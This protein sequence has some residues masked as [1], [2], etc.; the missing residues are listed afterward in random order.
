MNQFFLKPVICGIFFVLLISPLTEMAQ[1]KKI[2]SLRTLLKKTTVIGG[3]IGFKDTLRIKALQALTYAYRESRDFSTAIKYAQIAQ[4]ISEKL[5][6]NTKSF[7][8]KIFL[9]TSLKTVGDIYRSMEDYSNALNL[10]KKELKVREEIGNK[11]D[12]ALCYNSIGLI[13]NFQDDLARSLEYFFKA[14]KT[15]E[16]A[17]DK[18]ELTRIYN[19]LGIAYF[20]QQNITKALEY[21]TKE[22]VEGERLKDER[23]VATA[24]MNMGAIYAG[25]GN[26]DSAL[27]EFIKFQKISEKRNDKAGIALA[28]MDIGEIYARKGNYAKALEFNTKAMKLYEEA[29]YKSD[30]ALAYYN[31]GYIYLSMAIKG[32]QKKKTNLAAAN[33]YLKKALTLHEQVGQI[34]GMQYCYE[35]LSTLDS[36]TGNAKGELEN[37]KKYVRYGDSLRNQEN[38]VQSIRTEMNY[39][40]EKKQTSANLQ[41]TKKET[42]ATQENDKQKALRNLFIIAFVFMLILSIFIFK[43]YRQKKLVNNVISLQKIEVEKQK[44]IVEKNQKQ[45]IDSINYAK[46]IQSSMLPNYTILKKAFK[47]NFIFYKPKDIVSGDFY[48]FY[49]L[50]GKNETIVVIADCT[51]HG[52]PGAFLS[53]IGTTLLNEIV[54]HKNITDPAEIIK[55][56][57]AGLISTLVTKKKE[58]HS[59]G[60]DISICKIN[61]E[62]KTLYFAG[63]NQILCLVNDHQVEKIESQVNSIDGVFDLSYSGNFVSTE[64]KLKPSTALFMSTDGFADQTGE[65]TGKKF[66]SSRFES[67][68]TEIHIL[69]GDDQLKRIESSFTSWKGSQK[70]ID[71]ILVIGITI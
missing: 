21:Y 44:S 13:Y 51:G 24:H 64:K 22:V 61:T 70:Q 28:V 71:D 65:G 29:G 38:T 33:F 3:E 9:A 32:L 47:E 48:W 15:M 26:I 36:C 17:S 52:V 39:E 49:T 60:M 63:A 55:A 68:L 56:L 2:D 69:P 10:Y 31:Q 62:T 6:T 41:Q 25:Q 4:N 19:S 53:M 8:G 35:A 23:S 58:T 45:I 11:T 66:L 1:T 16:E 54:C 30:L 46:R 14:L 27:K 18:K 34:E 50:P 43:N 42:L 5:I 67:L 57:N 40:F 20:R 37:Y 12:L 7:K 59:D